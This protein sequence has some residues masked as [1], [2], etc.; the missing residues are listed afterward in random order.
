MSER[1]EEHA[2][3]DLVARLSQKFPT[4]AHDRIAT[5][6]REEQHRLDEGR[7]RGF[8]PVLVEHAARDRL[9]GEAEPADSPTDDVAAPGAVPAR[10]R[11]PVDL[12]PM[13]IERNSRRGGF[14]FGDIGGG[15]V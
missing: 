14:L 3:D 4:M 6:V 7:V 12:D 2:I 1:D 9:R 10:G 15:N 11:Q 13:E 5:V 8:V